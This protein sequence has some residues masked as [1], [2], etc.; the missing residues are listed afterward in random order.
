MLVDFS[1][2]E[3]YGLSAEQ[4][5]LYWEVTQENYQN[6]ASLGYQLLEPDLLLKLEEELSRRLEEAREAKELQGH[7]H[8]HSK[9]KSPGCDDNRQ[10]PGP[11]ETHS[12]KPNLTSHQKT[13]AE[14]KPP[15]GSDAGQ[16]LGPS[17]PHEAPRAHPTQSPGPKTYCVRYLGRDPR[18]FWEGGW[19]CCDCGKGFQRKSHLC[20]HY[21][22][23]AQQR[24]FQ[25]Q[26]CGRCFSWPSYLTQHYQLHSQKTALLPPCLRG[27]RFPHKGVSL[28]CLRSHCLP[29]TSSSSDLPHRPSGPPP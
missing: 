22:T 26:L 5:S 9:E 19:H 14:E 8:V 18:T 3:W 11:M 15:G 29:A 1:A 6:V 28:E 25:C 21:R 10:P 24:P 23:H 17:G 4:R 12:Q 16:P 27:S 7:Q 13:C 20:Q 2:D